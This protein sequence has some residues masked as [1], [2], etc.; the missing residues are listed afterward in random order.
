[1]KRPLSVIHRGRTGNR[2]FQ[3]LFCAELARRAG[4]HVVTGVH[5]PDMGISTPPG[6]ADTDGFLHF[7]GRHAF[8]L[9]GMA[10]ALRTGPHPGATFIGYA[11]RI[12][13]YHRDRCRELLNLNPGHGA[14]FGPE[15]LVINIR[16][17]DIVRGPT[18]E[19]MATGYGRPYRLS[20][21]YDG[22]HPDYRPLPVSFYERLVRETRLKPVFVGETGSHKQYESA[23]RQRFP[24]AVFTGRRTPREDFLTLMG[25]ANLVLAVST[26]SWLAGW[27][28][29]AR[30]IH[31]PIAG[32]LDPVQRPD[33]NLIPPASDARYIHHPFPRIRWEGTADQVDALFH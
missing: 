32:F 4:T 9:A 10:E 11:A 17:G 20:D 21:L 22:V 25:S 31:L 16:A 24:D 3:Y 12:E 14:G 30:T 19:L 6:P 23:L 5:I 18:P 15:F 1:M 8:D 2:L 13:Y 7:E 33:V 26:F 27:F 29:E 28:S